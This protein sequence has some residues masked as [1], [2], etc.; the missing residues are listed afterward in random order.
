MLKEQREEASLKACSDAK[1]GEDIKM[2]AEESSESCAGARPIKSISKTQARLG[3]SAQTDGLRLKRHDVEPQ[4]NPRS[5][6]AQCARLRPER[7]PAIVKTGHP[8]PAIHG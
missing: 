6:A 3:R 7:K 1:L 8:P 4:S 2:T 5:G